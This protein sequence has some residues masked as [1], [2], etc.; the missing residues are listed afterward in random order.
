[1][2][3]EWK[4]GAQIRAGNSYLQF[5]ALLNAGLD[6]IEHKILPPEPVEVNLFKISAERK[7]KNGC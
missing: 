3:P 5:A 1:M 7:E 6:G 4:L 2:R